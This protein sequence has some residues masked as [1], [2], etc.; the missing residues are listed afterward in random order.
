MSTNR[1]P[2]REQ[3]IL[4]EIEHALSQDRRLVRRLG[5]T[6]RRRRPDLSRIAAYTP[7]PWVVGLLLAVSVALMTAGAVTSEPGVIWGFAVVWPVALFAAFRLLCR[8]SRTG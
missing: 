1:L 5:S 7:R 3:R 6:R 2:D 4:D 8:W